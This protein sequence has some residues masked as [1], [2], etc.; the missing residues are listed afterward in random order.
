MKKII[1]GL[2]ILGAFL[3]ADK[4]YLTDGREM[5]GNLAVFNGS[6]ALRGRDT[7]LLFRESAV[8]AVEKDG[9]KYTPRQ[10]LNAFGQADDTVSVTDLDI[11]DRI[12]LYELDKGDKYRAASLAMTF[13]TMGHN[14]AGD[15]SRGFA[16]FLGKFIV[17]FMMAGLV[18]N[19]PQAEDG[20]EKQR[21][22]QIGVG[23]LSFGLMQLWEIADAMG[24]VEDKNNELKEKL[25]IAY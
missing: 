12:K 11:S 18:P 1:L 15:G 20:G 13:P 2:L 17:P 6:F 7:D 21:S 16:I 4:L 23:V 24:A 14:Y 5:S 19:D 22:V 3:S 9:V 8:E 25:G 10:Y